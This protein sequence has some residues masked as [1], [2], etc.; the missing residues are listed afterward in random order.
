MFKYP[1][2]IVEIIK[3]LWQK[4]KI[5]SEFID[6]LPED[7]ILKNLLEIAYH[8]SFMTEE[9]RRVR[10]SL[11]YCP[12]DSE[13]IKSNYETIVFTKSRDFSLTEIF[14][15]APATDPT[16]V[17][18][19][20]ES[21]KNDELKIWG[22]IDIGS[23]WTHF[24]KGDGG[25]SFLPPSFFT[26][27]SSEPG[28]LTISCAGVTVL[29]LR[30]GK[31]FKP[32]SGIF[33]YGI[34]A[35]FFKHSKDMLCKEIITKIKSGNFEKDNSMIEDF[36]KNIQI[37]FERLV[38]DIKEKFQ[39]GTI[40]VVPKDFTNDDIRLKE[41]VLIK[42]P[43]HYD[44]VWKILV[45]KNFL[46]YK[47]FELVFTEEIEEKEAYS[48][49]FH[50]YMF[51]NDKLKKIEQE[52]SD[53]IKFLSSLSEV[54]GAVI[55]TENLKLLGFG[56]EIIV[57]TNIPD[58]IKIANDCDGNLG[59]YISIDSY[60]T[61][62]RAAFR[63]CYSYENSLAF[64]VSKDGSLRAVKRNQNDIILWQDIGLFSDIQLK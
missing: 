47:L 13:K 50:E 61:R 55:I 17:L 64:V 48:E 39:G 46:N 54:D 58:L 23:S 14:R 10:F 18:I 20:V 51:L 21:E 4:N 19:G 31:Y 11:I 44:K 16:S 9:S 24:I 49:L 63:F 6:E 12:K 5:I 62:H 45:N 15:L 25:S 56:C 29:D 26:I 30:Q 38:F 7:K 32:V 36:Q 59:S 27:L 28:N 60:G 35:D 52:L 22:L 40:I 34:I 1:S 53:A 41:R 43:C 33:N 37:F 57:K 2:D 42:Y 8:S 3:D